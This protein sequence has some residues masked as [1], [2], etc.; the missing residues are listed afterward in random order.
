MRPEA[1]NAVLKGVGGASET[2]DAF[3]FRDKLKDGSRA[4]DVFDLIRQLQLPLRFT[5]LDPLLG[6]CVR[7]STTE[8]GILVTTRRDLHVQRFTAAHELGHFVL[9]HKKGSFD[10][11]V[12]LP[13]RVPRR[14][15]QEIEADAFAAELLMPKWLIKAIAQRREWWND[16]SLRDPAIIYQLSLRCATSYEATCWGLVAHDYI[17]AG[18]AKELLG[19]GRRLKKLKQSA[20]AGASLANPWANV[21]T[22]G[23]TDDGAYLEAGPDDLLIVRLRERPATGYRWDLAEAL[24][25]GFSVVDDSNSF[26]SNVVGGQ[27]ERRMVLGVP[28]SG[29]HE[30]N[31]RQRRSFSGAA[32]SDSLSLTVSCEGTR[33]PAASSGDDSQRVLH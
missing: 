31:L 1:R 3:R 10:T 5:A 2:H 9:G 32:G 8:V 27:A 15:P 4:L 33:Q 16:E 14:D 29:I 24:S 18:V 25:A 7:I 11:E 19:G 23:S 6:A 28:S 22:L 13:S 26:D 17:T 12:G 30:L 20:L 21:W